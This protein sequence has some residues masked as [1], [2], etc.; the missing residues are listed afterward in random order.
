MGYVVGDRVALFFDGFSNGV[1]RWEMQRNG[2][3]EVVWVCF[4]AF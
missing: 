4:G 2:V 3:G 1:N